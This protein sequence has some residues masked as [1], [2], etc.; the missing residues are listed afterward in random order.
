MRIGV[1]IMGGDYAPAAPIEGAILALKS[2][3][4]KAEIVLIGDETLI[5]SEQKK[6]QK[7]R[8]IKL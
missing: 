5:R 8:N 3:G 2:L 7:K 4:Q 1:D 6:R